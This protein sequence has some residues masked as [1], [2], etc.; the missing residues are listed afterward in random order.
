[1]KVTFRGFG[2]VAISGIL[3]LIISTCFLSALCSAADTLDK[4]SPAGDGINRLPL[5]FVENRGQLPDEVAFYTAARDKIVYFCKDGFTVSI[6]VRN[7]EEKFSEP[8]PFFEFDDDDLGTRPAAE[9]WAVKF[10]FDSANNAVE[11]SGNDAIPGYFNYFSGEPSDWNTE[12]PAYRTIIYRDLWPGIDLCFKTVDKSVKYEFRVSPNADAGRIRMTCTGATGLSINP[13]GGLLVET[14]AGSFEDQKP[15]AWQEKDG[16]RVPVSAEYHLG[17]PSDAGGRSIDFTL[18]NYDPALPLVIDPDLYLYCGYIGG[19]AYEEGRSIGVD[20]N[21]YVYVTG[22]AESTEATFPVT[23]GPYLVHSG[24]EDVFVAKVSPDGSQLVYCGYIGGAEED[25]SYGLIVDDAGCAYVVGDTYSDETTGF[26][27]VVGPSLT[28]MGDREA[29]I[30]KLNEAGTALIFSGF[31]GGVRADFGRGMTL[32][33]EGSIYIMGRTRSTEMHGFPVLVGPD[34]TYNGGD[35]DTYVAKVEADGSGLIYCGYI[36]GD[37]YDYG[38]EVGV[39]DEGYAYVVGWT[40]SE[41]DTFPV[42]IGPDL[43]YDCNSGNTRYG[44]GFV[45]KV[46]RSGKQLLYC[47][48]LGGDELDACFGIAVDNDGFAYIAGHTTS[49]ENSFPV[50]VGPDLTFNGS[51]GQYGDAFVAK[52]NPAGTVLLYCGYIGGA[53]GDRGWRIDIDDEGCA[54][55]VGLTVSDDDT[56]PAKHGPDVSYNGW[57][58]GFVAKVK[59]DGS[60]LHYCSYIGGLEADLVRD[61]AVDDAGNAYLI[62][63]TLSWP[64]TLDVSVGPDLTYNGQVDAL[65]VKVPPHHVLIRRGQIED[66]ITGEQKDMLFINGTAGDVNRTM[67]I[68]AGGTFNVSMDASPNGPSPAHYAVY[69]WLDEAGPYA[70]IEQDHG[71]GTSCFPLPLNGSPAMLVTLFNNIGRFNQLGYPYYSGQTPL[72]P[73]T[74]PSRRLPRGTYTFQAILQ[75]TVPGN[76]GLSLTN[77]IVVHQL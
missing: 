37:E 16:E 15:V 68:P 55:V 25:R 32:D 19:H 35:Q 34:L 5:C 60:D 75:D 50:A 52:L 7:E 26:P 38:R 62:G 4:A 39:D 77:A 72:A 13:S 2:Q 61:V 48:Y 3:F 20:P 1:M 28:S 64:D 69:C 49:D 46:S 76:E 67:T 51:V 54:Y 29:F 63:W 47:G 43:T 33:A 14:P 12:V 71:L 30:L 40:A 57:Q 6:P 73:M 8:E 11:A 66:S 44:D 58:D 31:I 10:E 24:D 17:Q 23:V 70:W 45:A 9:W 42:K 53:S 27:V 65:V 56:F 22:L 41:E 74:M 59:D 21:G 18:G 36:G